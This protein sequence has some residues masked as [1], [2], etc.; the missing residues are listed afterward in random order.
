MKINKAQTAQTAGHGVSLSAIAVIYMQVVVPMQAE[1]AELENQVVGRCDMDAVLDM[2]MAEDQSNLALTAKDVAD[3]Y[4]TMSAYEPLSENN[5]LRLE[6][7]RLQEQ[8]FLAEETRLL[9]LAEAACD[10]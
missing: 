8:Q 9:G 1:I 3:R 5:R 4:V 7:K 6:Q 10:G 2:A